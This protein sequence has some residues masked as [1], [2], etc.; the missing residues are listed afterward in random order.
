MYGS[1]DVDFVVHRKSM[2]AFLPSTDGQQ[3]HLIR[4]CYY[5]ARYEKKEMQEQQEH[6]DK[7]INNTDYYELRQ[8]QVLKWFQHSLRA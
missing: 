6:K 3:Y 1:P 7:T 5:D 8:V 2:M 4:I